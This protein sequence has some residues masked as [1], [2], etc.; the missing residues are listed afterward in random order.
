MGL[1]SAI[2]WFFK[3]LKEGEPK[4]PAPE[5]TPS[6]QPALQVLALLQQQGRLVDFL[7]EDIGAFSDAEIGAAVRDIHT[8]C[9]VTLQEHVTLAPI[10]DGEVETAITLEAGFDPSAIAVE[11][12]V[13]GSPPYQGTIL[14]RGWRAVEVKLPTVPAQADALVVQPAQ[15]EVR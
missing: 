4:P 2:K 11:G 6:S 10:V 12:N 7:M 5:F 15:V 3:V 8:K 14:H 13:T 9:R 1:A